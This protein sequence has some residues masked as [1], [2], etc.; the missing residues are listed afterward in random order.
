MSSTKKARSDNKVAGLAPEIRAELSRLL[1]EENKSFKDA[2]AW[3]LKT[4]G[5]KIGT[6]AL[7]NWYSVHSWTTSSASAREFAAQVKADQAASGDY[8]TATLALIQERAYIMARTQGADIKDLARL[9]GIIGSSAKLN[10]KERELELSMRKVAL[11][12][13]KAALADAAKGVISNPELS[14]AE[15]AQNLRSLFGMG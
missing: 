13:K 14:E 9:A 7:C 4:H 12:E 15:K 5:V 1:G 8:D 10:L 3:L 2:A 6:T 11:L